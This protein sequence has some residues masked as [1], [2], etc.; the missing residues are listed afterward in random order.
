[1]FA[2]QVADMG[3]PLETGTA[4]VMPGVATWPWRVPEIELD[5]PYSFPADV[6]P[7]GLAA[8][9]LFSVLDWCRGPRKPQAAQPHTLHLDTCVDQSGRIRVNPARS[10]T[11]TVELLV[12]V[13]TSVLRCFLCV[14]CSGVKVSFCNGVSIFGILNLKHGVNIKKCGKA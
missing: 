8:Y 10:S 6:W 13:S 9:A 2:P 1:M 12:S 4:D 7:L 5:L 11:T 14:C 3:W